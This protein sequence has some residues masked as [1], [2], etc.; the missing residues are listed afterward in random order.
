MGDRNESSW[1]MRVV[2]QKPRTPKS[3][4]SFAV[5][6]S[7]PSPIPDVTIGSK[8]VLASLFRIPI[9]APAP[10]GAW[11]QAQS[12]IPDA[13]FEAR[14][15]ALQPLDQAL[16]RRLASASA[17]SAAT[18]ATCGQAMLVPES[19]RYT[20][21]GGKLENTSIPGAARSTSLLGV[22][23]RTRSRRPPLRVDRGDRHD[24]WG[25]RRRGHRGDVA[26]PPRAVVAGGRDDQRALLE[27]EAPQA[28]VGEAVAL[29]AAPPGRATSRRPGT[30]ARSPRP[31]RR[32]CLFRR[33]CRCR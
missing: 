32:G 18:P 3:L 33:R 14:R 16:P 26:E 8:H 6:E 29:P 21:G 13:G 11:H 5:L 1:N 25:V 10:E 27:R 4:Q 12:D 15:R 17:Q 30:A 31:C 7:A 23:P 20:W 24:R 2:H 9:A 22:Q 28:L 19:Q